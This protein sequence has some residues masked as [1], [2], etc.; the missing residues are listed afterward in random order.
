MWRMSWKGFY[1]YIE[2]IITGGSIFSELCIYMWRKI[3]KLAEFF[4]AASVSRYQFAYVL[5]GQNSLK[6]PKK[7][8]SWVLKIYLVFKSAENC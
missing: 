5:L 8:E 6:S 4:S 2:K 1:F 3:G 7:S